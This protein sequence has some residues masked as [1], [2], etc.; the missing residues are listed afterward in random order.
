MVCRVAAAPY[1][2]YMTDSVGPASEAPPGKN[3]LIK[4]R[5]PAPAGC[6]FII[7]HAN[8]SSNE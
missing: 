3:Q 4:P 7:Y 1:P 6:L 5:H 8:I 2:A